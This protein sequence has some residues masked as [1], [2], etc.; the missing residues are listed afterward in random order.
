MPKKLGINRSGLYEK[1]LQYLFVTYQKLKFGSNPI[2]ITNIYSLFTW[3]NCKQPFSL[4]AKIQPSDET[5]DW[6]IPP[7]SW[8]KKW[9]LFAL[10]FLSSKLLEWNE[11]WP[12]RL[13]TA[14]KPVKTMSWNPFC[15]RMNLLSFALSF[16]RAQ[17]VLCW[18]KLFEP[19]QKFECIQC[20]LKNF[21]ACKKNQFYWI[22]II[23]L[24]ETKC[25]WLP[26]YINKFLFWHQKLGPAQN[27]LDGHLCTC[28]V[29]ILWCF[30]FLFWVT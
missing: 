11:M 26:Q 25:L 5:S 8:W 6:K 22:Q 21:C 1:S 2:V 30:Q 18:S 20:L 29:L 10:S 27:I 7:E 3:N 9:S 16:Y 19:A 23:F 15:T 12:S 14:N 24:S 17:N 4:T 28:C 13:D